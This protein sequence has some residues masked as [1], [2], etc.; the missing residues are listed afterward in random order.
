M[1]MFEAYEKH[2]RPEDTALFAQME[3]DAKKDALN[4]WEDS[5]PNNTQTLG[6]QSPGP[7]EDKIEN[8]S[9]ETLTQLTD[10]D[11]NRIA[12]RLAELMGQKGGND[13]DAGNC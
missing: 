3:A 1:D 5:E 8:V 11:V 4:L 9:R 2:V 12:T 6:E 10:E 7:S 13:G